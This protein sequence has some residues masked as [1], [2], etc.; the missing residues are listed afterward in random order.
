MSRW[1]P[2]LLLI[3]LVA[4]AGEP[5]PSPLLFNAVAVPRSSQTKAITRATSGITWRG[6]RFP[7]QRIPLV[8]TADPG[9]SGLFGQQFDAMGI[10]I[11]APDGRPLI[12]NSID[13]LSLLPTHGRLFS[14]VHGEC[15]P[16]TLSLLELEQDVAGNLSTL[17]AEPIDL[18][19]VGGG[20]NYCAGASTSWGSHLA[21]EEYE[22]DAAKVGPDGALPKDYYGYNRMESYLGTLEGTS[23]YGYGWINEV[24][25]LS[26]TGDVLVTKRTAIGRFSHEQAHVLSDD[27]TVYLS[28]DG[29]NGG[30]YL[31]VA[32]MAGDLSV[33]KLYAARWGET[34]DW[35]PL[36]RA[37]EAQ[38]APWLA[39]NVSFNELFDRVEP[40]DGACAD[41]FGSVATAW[42][43]ECLRVQPGAEIAASRLETRRFAALRGATTEFSKGEGLAFGGDTL[44]MALARVQGSMLA[45]DP[46]DVGGPDHLGLEPNPC[47]AVLAFDLG[48]PNDSEGHP[49]DSAFVV[50]SGRV[51]FE[52][53]QKP[54]RG[55]RSANTCDLERIAGPDNLAFI[56]EAGVLLVAEDTARHE[57]N[58]LWAIDVASGDHTRILTVPLKAEVAGL[59]WYPDIGGH[60][61]ITFAVQNPFSTWDDP[62]WQDATDGDPRSWV[63]YLGPFPPLN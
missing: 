32:D 4:H 40:Q 13:G 58:A 59:Q 44:Y 31:F 8:H 50:R 2:A 3:P 53:A 15:S 47:G 6:K 42:G 23:P 12:C 11:L 51:A 20:N 46:R 28:D 35:V 19:S 26:E 5:E 54:Y 57:N 21:A 49:I 63:G 34:V 10:G 7:L 33:G 52:G 14:V 27:R 17:R 45:K 62:N 29:K 37:S 55:A 56:P 25:V 9:P 39:K 60:G 16:G 30:L 22:A 38:V 36:G 18:S 43:H 48:E 41:G 61:Y 1:L 24:Q